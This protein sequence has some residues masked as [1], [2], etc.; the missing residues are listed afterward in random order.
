MS[1]PPDLERVV[2]VWVFLDLEESVLHRDHVLV[3]VVLELL[4]HVRHILLFQ[5]QQLLPHVHAVAVALH[6]VNP[7]VCLF[8]LNAVLLSGL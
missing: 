8:R 4:L 1:R 2:V 6:A 3:L 5:I 7:P